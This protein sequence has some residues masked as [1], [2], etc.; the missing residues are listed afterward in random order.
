MSNKNLTWNELEAEIFTPEEIAESR[1]RVEIKG[2]EK[3][4]SEIW[5]D[6][7]MCELGYGNGTAG[8]SILC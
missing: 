2:T 5:T 3:V 7:F 8:R 6:F 1:A 4:S